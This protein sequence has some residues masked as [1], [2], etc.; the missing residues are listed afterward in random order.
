MCP[1]AG[2]ASQPAFVV[3][4]SSFSTPSRPVIHDMAEFSERCTDRR[5]DAHERGPRT[6]GRGRASVLGVIRGDPARCTVVQKSWTKR[7]NG[8]PLPPRKPA[9]SSRVIG[10]ICLVKDLCSNRVGGRF[11]TLHIWGW[12]TPFSTRIRA[13]VRAPH[14]RVSGGAGDQMAT[15]HRRD[16]RVD[17]NSRMSISNG[18]DS[19]IASCPNAVCSGFRM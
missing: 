19:W 10:C 12:M 9:A 13:T 7:R 14:P 17:R 15:D 2:N 16:Q 3:C 4:A 6:P 1:G 18:P 8:R 5:V 11:A